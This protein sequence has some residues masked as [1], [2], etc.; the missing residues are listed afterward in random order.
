[1]KNKK[2]P[3]KVANCTTH[4]YGCACREY[5]YKEMESALKVIYT[6]CTFDGGK[7]A[8]ISDIAKMCKETLWCL[9]GTI[10]VY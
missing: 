2:I 9:Q 5:R 8:D 7:I 1:M 3:K 6:W 4:S 10:H